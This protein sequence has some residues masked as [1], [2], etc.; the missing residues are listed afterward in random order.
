MPAEVGDGEGEEI[1]VQDDVEDQEVEEQKVAPNP[2]LP[3]AEEVDEH[4]AS[5]HHPYRIW[6]RECVEGRAVGEHHAQAK[7]AKLIPTVAFDYFFLTAGGI[8]HRQEILEELGEHCQGHSDEVQLHKGSVGTR[9]T[10]QG[11]G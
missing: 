7:H 3:S 6:C 8:Q 1:A 11:S 4:R 10:L 2:L 5:G 9:D